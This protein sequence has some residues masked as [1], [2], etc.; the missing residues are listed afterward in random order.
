MKTPS[1]RRK[2]L[3]VRFPVWPGET[4]P[5]FF[6][7]VACAHATRPA[8]LTCASRTSYARLAEESRALAV[9][10]VALGVPA[11]A[12]IGLVMANHPAFVTAKLAIAHAGCVA[13]PINPQLLRDEMGYILRHAGCA[14][15]IA[16]AEFRGRDYRDD[17]AALSAGLPALRHIIVHAP[18]EVPVS[19]FHSLAA[20]CACKDPAALAQVAQRQ[21]DARADDCTDIIY[22]S[23]TTGTPKGVMLSHDMILRAAW[24]SALT[25]GFEDGR[26][27]QFALPMHHVF[28]LV[29]CWVASLFVGGAIIPHAVFDAA[30]MLEAADRLGATDMVCVPAMTQAL[31]AAARSRGRAPATLRA[32][33]NSGAAN[34]PGIWAE[35]RAALGVT[36]IHT[37]YGMTETTASIVCTRV[38][39]GDAA[40]VS[41][42]GRA[43]LAGVAGGPD[44]ALV[45]CRVV[46]PVSGVDLGADAEGELQVRG[47]V[48]TP[49]YYNKPEETQAA[50]APGGWLRTGDLVRLLPD[51]HLRLT[52][53]IKE[54]YRC[55][56][57]MVMPREIE[58]VLAGFP[59]VATV[60]AVG[61]A[62]ARMG[63]VGCLCVV[64][65]AGVEPDG[66]AMLALCAERLARFKVPRHALLFA[67]EE[68]PLTAT[69]RP[70]R[71]QLAELA[72]ARI[73]R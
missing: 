35:I 51:G 57:E 42:N 10:L 63:E 52:G 17:L 20:L 28:G 37:A 60:I 66:A 32:F 45:Q 24:S 49:G 26:R 40:L 50:F 27:I 44:G 56:G 33:F 39:D 12:R 64:A 16:M 72:A 59:G 62:D 23:G 9:G 5:R 36:E 46:D 14:A 6:D 15:V 30:E 22:T 61:I 48:V 8:I 71:F 11:G 7:S 58:D 3:G 67:A 38:E 55:G 4:L 43:K 54:T 41:T 19:P 21:A 68:I 13:V 70:R 73:N 2:A 65:E 53:R 34:P 47:A 18:P 31:I 25:R 1:E 29:E 69:G